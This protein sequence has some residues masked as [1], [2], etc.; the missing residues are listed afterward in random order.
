MIN[1][2]MISSG[3]VDSKIKKVRQNIDDDKFIYKMKN[4][5]RKKK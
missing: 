2:L 5:F 3:S 4:N 1:N